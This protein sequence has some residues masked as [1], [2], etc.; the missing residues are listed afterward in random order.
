M[1]RPAI[2]WLRRDL[3]LTDNPALSAAC[4]STDQVLPV[5][6]WSPEEEGEGAPGAAQ[7]WWLHNSLTALDDGLRRAV[8]GSDAV[9]ASLSAPRWGFWPWVRRSKTPMVHWPKPAMYPAR[10]WKISTISAS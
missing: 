8:D 4:G 7:R 6:I 10:G 1:G 3:R 9:I 5:Y 2:V